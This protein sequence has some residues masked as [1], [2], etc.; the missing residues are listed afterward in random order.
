MHK[1]GL[2]G[3]LVKQSEALSY[4]NQAMKIWQKME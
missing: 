3:E 4:P 2:P 1:P